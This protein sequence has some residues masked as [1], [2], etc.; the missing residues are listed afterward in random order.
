MRSRLFIRF[1]LRRAGTCAN[2]DTCS[3]ANAH[4]YSRAYA[5][6]FACSHANANAC[7]NT[8]P[9]PHNRAAQVRRGHEGTFVRAEGF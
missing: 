2:A 3:H 7:A 9:S 5:Y 6:T 8:N 1:R 4:T